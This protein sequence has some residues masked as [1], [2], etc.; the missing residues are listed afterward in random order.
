VSTR[1]GPNDDKRW[2]ATPRWVAE[3]TLGPVPSRWQFLSPEQWWRVECRVGAIAVREALSHVPDRF[4]G[5]RTTCGHVVALCEFAAGQNVS[6]VSARSTAVRSSQAAEAA[7]SA[8]AAAPAAAA[9]CAQ[10]AAMHDVAAAVS[11]AMRAAESAQGVWPV[12]SWT[13]AL[14]A[15]WTAEAERAKR[16]VSAFVRIAEQIVDLIELEIRDR[17]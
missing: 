12:E 4:D 11:A 15:A 7:W 6:E 9:W 3:L 2:S 13:E 10:Y 16:L 17:A 14:T 5:V 1:K 8:G